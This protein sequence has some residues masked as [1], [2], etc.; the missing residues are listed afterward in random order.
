MKLPDFED[1]ITLQKKIVYTTGAGTI[2]AGATKYLPCME[3]IGE[4]EGATVPSV[5]TE[6]YIQFL[7]L[8]KAILKNLVA[9]STAFP[10]AAQTFTYMV[11]VNRAN[12]ALTTTISGAAQ[13]DNSDLVNTVKVVPGDRITIQVINSAGG[14]ATG[15]SACFTYEVVVISKDFD[16]VTFSTQTTTPPAGATSYIASCFMGSYGEGGTYSGTETLSRLAHLVTRKGT[17]KNMVTYVMASPG[18]LKNFVYTIRIN[19]V[20]TALTCT[21]SGAALYTATD[22]VNIAQ[23][24]PGDRITVEVVTDAASTVTEHMVS[25][26][27][28]VGD[29]RVGLD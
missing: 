3:S 1:L 21:I 26:E 15:H 4:A 11:R 19:G 12:T 10:G 17:I 9:H 14:A 16:H 8:R 22:L 25:F 13:R 2:A 5:E 23:I 6:S 28:E 24:D 20:D 27:I 18:A 7:V 29:T